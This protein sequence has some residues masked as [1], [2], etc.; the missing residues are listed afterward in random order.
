MQPSTRRYE[1][2][3]F[4]L[5]PGEGTLVAAG[6][7]VALAPKPFEVLRL[8]VERHGHVVLKSE[9]MDSIWRDA[10][11]EEANLTVSVSVLRK[12]LSGTLPA[13]HYIETVPKRGYRFAEQVREIADGDADRPKTRVVVG[14]ER[15]HADL[16][17]AL[18]AAAAGTATLIGITGE[19][20]IG[21]TS[22]IEDFIDRARSREGNCLVA[23]GRC[24]EHLPG[25]DAFFPILQAL[26]DVV[27]NR[28]ALTLLMKESAPTWHAAIE[29]ADTFGLPAGP[30]E[31]PGTTPDQLRRELSCFLRV[32]ARSAPI[33]LF[34][35]D[36]HWSDA[37]T[38][39]LLRFLAHRFALDSARILTVVAYRPAERVASGHLF[40]DLSAQVQS[41]GPAREIV[42]DLL[43]RQDIGRY[44]ATRFPH[45]SFSAAFADAVS[46]TTEGNP[47]FM[48][49]LVT[50]LVRRGVLVQCEDT[51][52]VA[53]GFP[54][55]QDSLPR[56][57]RAMVER[58]IRQ[59]E[60]Q[61]RSLLS[62]ATLQGLQF[63][64]SIL[65]ETLGLDP[66]HIEGRLN[67]LSTVHGI[68]RRVG[69]T[70]K[71]NGGPGV[72]FT[73]IHGLH[74]EALHAALSPTR[75]ALLS[76]AVAGAVLE[77]HRDRVSEV[78][79]TLAW[80]FE[81]AHDH[82]RASEYALV[83]AQRAVRM[84]GYREAIGFARRGL[85]LLESVPASP[86]RVVPSD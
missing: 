69:D 8:L 57:V 34:I 32:A 22:L 15:E 44:L 86:E 46:R 21:K 7:P 85:D 3:P 60:N 16:Q 28:D 27:G 24:L 45:N 75:K 76:A 74:R 83:A 11:V 49:D 14:R 9:L 51:W 1:F 25:V 10:A 37:S 38:I 26:N 47:L 65:A 82:A 67:A 23:R 71:G 4:Q 55:W 35:D 53:G 48:A 78:A 40:R 80:L 66:A 39:E 54:D 2:G 31:P 18:R 56:S 81:I 64:S 70:S 58:T 73:F 30:G 19:P 5:N 62:A 17:V 84:A 36:L 42:L 12:T 33:V 20:G 79:S 59:L 41:C 29:R 6:L 13:R 52:V 50:D 77:R 43:S 63:D 72:H 68:V 61:D